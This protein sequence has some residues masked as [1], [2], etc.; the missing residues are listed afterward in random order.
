MTINVPKVHRES[1]T[2]QVAIH[3]VGTLENTQIKI[4]VVALLQ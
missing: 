4:T 2:T 1:Y 3:K